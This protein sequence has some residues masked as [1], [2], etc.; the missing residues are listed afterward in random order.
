MAKRI[1]MGHL[2][3]GYAYQGR[4]QELLEKIEDVF[5]FCIN[6]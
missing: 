6:L 3:L 1:I 5:R 4:G 2:W